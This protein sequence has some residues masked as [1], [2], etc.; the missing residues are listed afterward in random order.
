MAILALRVSAL[1]VVSMSGVMYAEQE[2][3]EGRF[4]V[5][6][7][8]VTVN[9]IYKAFGVSSADYLIECNL[10]GTNFLVLQPRTANP[11][12]SPIVLLQR[13]E[14]S[15][16]R[17]LRELSGYSTRHETPLSSAG[18]ELPLFSNFRGT[19]IGRILKVSPSSL[20]TRASY[21][22]MGSSEGHIFKFKFTIETKPAPSHP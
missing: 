16:P 6:N 5:K 15:T 13:P 2:V 4:R 14:G 3:E 21:E 17:Q 1:E 18:D 19:A 12:L 8:P 10:Q 20:I 7:A 9:T 11:N 22:V